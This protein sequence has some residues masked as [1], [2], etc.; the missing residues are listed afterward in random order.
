MVSPGGLWLI[1]WSLAANGAVLQADDYADLQSAVVAAADG[2]TIQLSALEYSGPISIKGKSLT[3]EGAGAGSVIVGG[4]LATT[5]VEMSDPVDI[6]LRSL[7]V[8]GGNLSRCL[9]VVESSLSL[10]NV[11]ITNGVNPDGETIAGAGLR[12]VGAEVVIVDSSFSSNKAGNASNGGSIGLVY[13]TMLTTAEPS[14]IISRTTFDHGDA[15]YGGA[16]YATKGHLVEIDS[17]IFETNSASYGGAI[18]LNGILDMTITDSSFV[19]NQATLSGGAIY[20]TSGN[21]TISSSDFSDNSADAEGGSLFIDGASLT[22]DGS[23]FSG[24][25]AVAGAAIGG[26]ASSQPSLLSLFMDHSTFSHNEAADLGGAVWLN[27]SAEVEIHRSRF[28][29]NRASSGGSVYLDGGD[30]F[31]ATNNSFVEEEA[32]VAGGVLYL[33]DFSNARLGHNAAVGSSVGAFLFES[34]AV[35]FY[36]NVVGDS[37]G[38]QAVSE[39]GASLLADYNA[40]FENAGG[41][42]SQS[43]GAGSIESVDP[44][45]MAYSADGDCTNDDLSPAPNSP[46]IDAG[47]LAYSSD[48]DGSRADIGL[49]GG[50][51]ADLDWDLDGSDYPGDCDELD[52]SIYP[53]SLAAC[54]G[55]DSDCDGFL[56]LDEDFDQDGH[57]SITCGGDD[58]DDADATVY[59]G[60]PSVCDGLDNDCDGSLDQLDDVDGD[61]EVGISCG[62]TDCDDSDDTVGQ[63]ANEL[64][65]GVDNNCDGRSDEAGAVDGVAYV[66]DIDQD[67]FGS[68]A[69]VDVSSGPYNNCVLLVD[70]SIYCWGNS[71]YGVNDS[72]DGEYALVSV[73]D[74]HACALSVAGDIECWTSGGSIDQGQAHPPSGSFKQVSSG[75][76]HSCGLD[77]QGFIICWGLSDGSGL[78]YGQVTDTPT[79]GGFLEVSAGVNHTCAIDDSS[80]LF[81]WGHDG[82]GQA[83]P[84]VGGPYAGVA[85][86]TADSCALNSAG[87]IDCWGASD[88]EP[89]DGSYINI[90][91][92]KSVGCAETTSGELLCFGALDSLVITEAPSFG[93]SRVVLGGE[94][95]C[96]VNLAQGI[97]CWGHDPA[98]F[99][100]LETGLGEAELYCTAPTGDWVADRTDCVAD[101]LAISPGANEYCDGLD[102]NC[103]EEIDEVGS[104]DGVAYYQ[105]ID[106]DGYG[107]ESGAG[108][109][110]CFAPTG[111]V[112]N[113]SDCLDSD[114]DSY[115]GATETC[116]T[117][118]NDCDGEIDEAGSL[119]GTLY[120]ID[121]D[122][123]GFGDQTDSGETY[124]SQPKEL[125]EDNTDCDDSD[126]AISPAQFDLEICDGVDNDCDGAVDDADTV[127]DVSTGVTGYLDV[128]LD[129][130][131]DGSQPSE[132]CGFV[133]GFVSDGSDCDDNNASVHPSQSEDCTTNI[134]DNCDGYFSDCDGADND[135]DGYCGSPRGESCDSPSNLPGDCDDNDPARHPFA[136]I[137]CMSVDNDCDGVTDEVDEDIDGDGFTGIGACE[138]SKDDCNDYLGSIYPGAMEQCN[139]LDDDCNGIVD[140]DPTEALNFF[141]DL[142][143]DNYPAKGSCNQPLEMI[144][145]DDEDASINPGAAEDPFDGVDNDCDGYELDTNNVDNDRDGHCEGS[146]FSLCTSEV[147]IKGIFDCDDGDPTRAPD[148]DE[149]QDGIDNDCDGIIDNDNVAGEFDNDGDGYCSN[150]LTC[151]LAS[152]LQPGDCDDFDSSVHPG[153]S[154]QCNGRDDN[155]DGLIWS[156][157]DE[158][159][160]DGDGVLACDDCD[161]LSAEA[162]PGRAEDCSDKIDND[163]DGTIDQSVDNDGDGYYTCFDDCNDAS[164][165]AHQGATEICDGIDNDC[166]GYVDEGFDDDED[167]YFQCLNCSAIFPA[168]LC[169]CDDSNALIRPRRGEDCT[170][171]IDNDCDGLIDVG[172]DNDWDQVDRCDGDC[173]DFNPDIN[174]LKPEV[175]DGIDN[176]CNGEVDETFDR[177]EDGVTS[178]FGDCEDDPEVG[179]EYAHAGLDEDDP[180]DCD[181]L[182]NDCNGVVDDLWPDS[183]MDGYTECQ[184]DCDSEAGT[185]SPGELEQCDDSVDNDCD[186]DVDEA[187]LDCVYNDTGGEQI[188]I[189]AVGYRSGWFCGV[190]R[191]APGAPS[192]A[193]LLLLALFGRRGQPRS[194][195]AR[196][197]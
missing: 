137:T 50:P 2:D 177:D 179:G 38:A 135:G 63:F 9:S 59:V 187:D 106:S 130:Y 185:S 131:G 11:V 45:F 13:S 173:D 178:C 32:V 167:G 42:S 171:G 111:A 190:S 8:D 169:D 104:V 139:G 77:S 16:L 88:F 118:D 165:V 124:C 194:D 184:G 23:S 100:L 192:A 56:E 159:D 128:D 186:G 33:K 188:V 94:H 75:R 170:D 19:D 120:Y 133:A 141:I 51:G 54:D 191:G 182:D 162:Y 37:A 166:D 40:Y 46:L 34:S 105:D 144:D 163:C 49:R 136:P 84:P 91:V 153:A 189:E 39:S 146:D 55:V 52:A 152:G 14:L 43:L 70:G 18:Y 140:D 129:G 108:E 123:D 64:C 87:G 147:Q 28:C 53:G 127:W 61:G 79:G 3:I 134:D 126:A 1:L 85:S 121:Q 157:L 74:Y 116:D 149:I 96:G 78:D 125:V 160:L 73:G 21:T 161:D 66:E 107:D 60:A 80:E 99:G 82:D 154:E 97:V 138:G 68:L 47:N 180:E 35:D 69:S 181:E 5:I 36:H 103:D 155:C 112:A 25:A 48:M 89:D 110:Y 10:D 24:S 76:Y 151:E 41:H 27:D 31:N 196:V 20:L 174:P 12:A 83:T 143:E 172:G 158:R 132:A 44:L 58:C 62:G 67:G 26:N 150:P 90:S 114:S 81:C 15:E 193:L 57:S 145:C 175:C 22:I 86:G 197:L 7:T 102:N 195:G 71:S 168:P 17:S 117:Q 101:D 30:A 72:P 115:P 176:N 142:D 148:K 29:S 119:D 93:I 122:L 6:T 109:L 95:A 98:L 65:D 164:A 183:D 92:G 4:G 113:N 156:E